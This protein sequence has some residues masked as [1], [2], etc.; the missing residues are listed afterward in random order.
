MSEYK[1]VATLRTYRY[2][3]R[4][5]TEAHGIEYNITETDTP[6]TGGYINPVTLCQRKNLPNLFN[7]KE[8]TPEQ[9][10]QR[11]KMAFLKEIAEIDKLT[12]SETHMPKWWEEMW[13]FKQ[14]LQKSL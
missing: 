3:E 6:P 5:S 7:R 2:W 8:E 1:I 4:V 14:N 10:W 11:A 13:E 12:T 9:R